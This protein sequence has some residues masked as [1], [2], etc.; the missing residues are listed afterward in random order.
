MANKKYTLGS[1]GYYQT[2]VWDGT[3]TKSGHKHRI[4]LRSAKCCRDLE[5]QVAEMK[6][7]VEARNF[8]R[9]TNILFI[10]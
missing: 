6:A 4:T 5:R 3:Y 9:D 1:D 10:S 2:K 7:Q 8:V